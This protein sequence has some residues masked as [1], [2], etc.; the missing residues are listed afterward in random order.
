MTDE[1]WPRSGY[2]GLLLGVK[3]GWDVV[4]LRVFMLCFFVAIGTRCTVRDC[5]QN[6]HMYAPCTYDDYCSQNKH[7]YAHVRMMT[8]ALIEQSRSRF[9]TTAAHQILSRKRASSRF[10][11]PPIHPFGVR[12]ARRA[13]PCSTLPILAGRGAGGLGSARVVSRRGVAVF[14][15][16]FKIIAP[17]SSVYSYSLKHVSLS[18][19][20]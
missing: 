7:V 2:R 16:C 3:S 12:C 1:T 20:V 5:S 10:P 13:S 15:F 9:Q 4:L 6:K 17:I 18:I 14:A 19:A 8:Q 11:P